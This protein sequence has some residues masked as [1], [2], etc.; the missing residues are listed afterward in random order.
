MDSDRSRSIPAA[1]SA[2][3]N[4]DLRH[5]LARLWASSA[6]RI[7]VAHFLAWLDM[8][9]VRITGCTEADLAAYEASLARF[10]TGVGKTYAEVARALV[11]RATAAGEADI[12]GLFGSHSLQAAA[13]CQPQETPP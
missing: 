1:S 4:A 11:Q 12:E 2:R 13:E 7:R 9:G 6:S 3:G 10:R 8:R 5:E